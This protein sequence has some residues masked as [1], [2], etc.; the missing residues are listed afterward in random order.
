MLEQGKVRGDA[1][2]RN[3][4]LPGDR[5]PLPVHEHHHKEDD[6]SPICYSLPQGLPPVTPGEKSAQ[7]L[8]MYFSPLQYFPVL[9]YGKATPFPKG[10]M[11]LLALR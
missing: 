11:W 3:W 5:P 1:W 2:T 8:L 10:K 4:F 9:I 7:V 6:H